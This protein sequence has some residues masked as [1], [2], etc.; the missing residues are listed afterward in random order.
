VKPPSLF[1]RLPFTACPSLTLGLRQGRL[2]HVLCGSHL[3][4]YF[5]EHSSANNG[6]HS[7]R[8]NAHA[9][10]HRSREPA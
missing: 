7:I 6:R 2:A 3:P 9:V 8:L 5:F 10:T 4:D 1:I